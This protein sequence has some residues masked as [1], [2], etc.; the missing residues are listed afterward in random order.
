MELEV[1]LPS[2]KFLQDQK[3]SCKYTK[4]FVLL[5]NNM[6]LEMLY[7]SWERNTQN[8]LY[9]INNKSILTQCVEMKSEVAFIFLQKAELQC[10]SGLSLNVSTTPI[11]AMGCRQW[12]SVSVV[13]LKGKHYRKP[14]CRNGVVD[15]FGHV[16]LVTFLFFR[17]GIVVYFNPKDL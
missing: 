4:V 8:H 7:V 10:P 16:V 9:P 6:Y 17:L 5:L 1:N 2:R 15:T 11:T 3:K 14:H 12:L 13:Q